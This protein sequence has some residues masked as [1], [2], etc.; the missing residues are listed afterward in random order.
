MKRLIALLVTVLTLF[1]VSIAAAERLDDK[2]LMSFYDNCLMIGDSRMENFH[3][4]VSS[5]RQNDDQFF[6]NTTI[7]GSH[8][9]SLHMGSRNIITTSPFFYRAR[10]NTMYG[11]ADQINAKRVIIL[12][13]LNDTIASKPDKAVEWVKDIFRFMKE[14]ESKPEVYFLSETPV[15]ANY[16][17]R[18]NHPEYQEELDAYNVLLKELCESNGAHYI[19]I[20]EPLKGEDNLLKDEYSS[21]RICHLNDKGYA[22]MVQCMFDYAQEQYDLGLWKPAAEQFSSPEQAHDQ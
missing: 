21:D 2:T 3:Y 19:E 12:L 22:I 16:G 6:K 8:S 7:V 5:A 1:S 10:R 17:I 13:G 14:T 4:Y 18:K 15:T 9:M 20:S 11:I